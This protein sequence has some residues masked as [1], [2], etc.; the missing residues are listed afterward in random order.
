[1]SFYYSSPY[2]PIFDDLSVA[3]DTNWRTG[4]I[5]GN[6]SG[7]TTL[8]RLISGELEPMEGEVILG[9]EAFYFPY[10]PKDVKQKTLQVIKE[11]IA[12]F[13]AWEQEMER[14]LEVGDERSLARYGE[15]LAE[16][17][18]SGGYEINYMI[19]KEFAQMGMTPDLLQRDFNSL[20]G[21][22][23]T[24]AL[25]CSLFL[26][27]GV[28]P[29]IDEPTNH[30]DMEGRE[31]LGKY[32]ARKQ[33]FILV[34]HDRHFL[35]LCIDHVLSINRGDVQVSQ[36][37]YSQWKEN[38]EREEQFERRQNE[39]LE[40]EIRALELAAR[41]RRV[42]AERREREKI[43]RG[44]KGFIGHRAA[45]LM[46]Q[47][48]SIERRIGEKVEEK[49]G[50]LKNIE[51]ERRLKMFTGPKSPEIVLSM[52]GVTIELGNRPIVKDFSLVLSKGERI[53]LLGPNGSG[54]T[55][56]LRAICG[57]IEV[58]D[59]LIHIP[60]YLTVARAYQEPLWKEGHLR[61]RLREEGIEEARFRNIMALLGVRGEIFERPL[62]TF[63][64]GE[65]KKI[66]LCRSFLGQ[67]QLFL[68]DEPLNYLDVM[69]REQIERLTLKFQPTMLFVEH[70]RYFIERVA[71]RTV[72]LEPAGR[73]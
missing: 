12:P 2:T 40:R 16:Y 7:K 13:S 66:D 65:R 31:L 37:N 11:S 5:G 32:L 53:A 33:G 4:V 54:K 55:T 68:W 58:A 1:V 15:I 9:E 49:R 39:R 34:S 59:G 10:R 20:S 14:L 19:E 23:Q 17:E 35:D 18:Q 25:I 62:E 44:D 24:R 73:D 29:L 61:D 3:I 45:K 52:D 28:F 26:K 38:K 72:R 42:W 64:E 67:A 8:L 41:K 70:D 71:T 50:L 36:G 47:A 30:L 46:R 6:G 63:S 57:E 48:L 21:G 56:L 69:T 43:G 60:K 51:K 27:E 22:E